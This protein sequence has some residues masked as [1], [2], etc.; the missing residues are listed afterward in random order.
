MRENTKT[1]GGFFAVLLMLASAALPAFERF[2][3]SKAKAI[4]DAPVAVVSGPIIVHG[5][6]STGQQFEWSADVPFKT[7]ED[8]KCAALNV[9]GPGVYRVALR[10]RSSAGG[11]YSEDV[12]GAVV[13][14]GDVPTPPSPGPLPPGPQPGPQPLPDG[15]F[16]LARVTYDAVMKLNRPTRRDEARAVAA[17]FRDIVQAIGDRKLSGAVPVAAATVKA[18]NE[19]LGAARPAW[20]SAIQEIRKASMQV[21]KH[22]TPDADIAAAIGEIATGL[23]A[24]Q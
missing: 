16:K 4:V 11:K 9:P 22:S 7:V 5:H 8:G 14:V 6:R 17:R 19:A 20:E 23:E 10:V 2:R 21:L 15:R 18:Q 24:V 12:A 3:N 13:V 1:V